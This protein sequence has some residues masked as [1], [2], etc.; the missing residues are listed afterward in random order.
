M[1]NH[2]ENAKPVELETVS[3]DE[4]IEMGQALERLK[5]NPDFQRVITDG[6]FKNSVLD[7]VSLLSVPQIKQQGHRPELMED[8]IAVSNLQFYFR[9]IEQFY[10][11][12]K[13]PVLSDEEEA[14]MAKSEEG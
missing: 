6:Y 7:T 9:Q 8:L 2:Q 12:A 3:M 11:A 13:N 1:S 10:E 5:D 14:E 4:Q